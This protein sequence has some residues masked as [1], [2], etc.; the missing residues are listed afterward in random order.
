MTSSA[1]KR[2]W[3]GYICESLVASGSMATWDATEYVT[4]NLFGDAPNPRLHEA[5]APYEA[6]WQ[7]LHRMYSPIVEAASREID[8]PTPSM[9][10]IFTDVSVIG[11]SAV[12][13]VYFP[14][15]NQPHQLLLLDSVR[16]WDL[17]FPDAA[18]FNAWA[19]ERFNWIAEALKANVARTAAK[20]A[21]ATA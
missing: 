2:N 1:V 13:V 17:V 8:L 18:A 4:G 5:K 19:E 15:G 20:P 3:V 7:F 6:I 14:G 9:I 11:K 10:H 21:L 16:A 12:L